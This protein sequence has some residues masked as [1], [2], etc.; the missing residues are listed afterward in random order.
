[1]TPLAIITLLAV[2][3]TTNII[4]C[5]SVVEMK[6]VMNKQQTLS[7]DTLDSIKTILE[8]ISDRAA[9]I[10][11]ELEKIT[12]DTRIDT[13]LHVERESM[14]KI[15]HYERYLKGCALKLV[16]IRDMI[17]EIWSSIV[18]K[19]AKNEPTDE[20]NQKECECMAEEENVA[21]DKENEDRKRAIELRN[22]GWGYNRIAK[23]LHRG[24][25]TIHTWLN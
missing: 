3:A 2:L 12:E 21:Q 6:S 18:S 20:K 15:V 11:V 17:E 23:E 10:D 16:S 5:V 1:M 24:N 14:K 19:R 8:D 4:L 25:Q 22:Q 9:S 7:Q 13:L